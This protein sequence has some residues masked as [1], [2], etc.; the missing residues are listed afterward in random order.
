MTP[1]QSSQIS[2]KFQ[3]SIPAS[4]RR[5]LKLE[6]GDRLNWRII[7]RNDKALVLA[8][9]TAKNLAKET[10]GLGKHLWENIDIKSYINTLRNEWELSK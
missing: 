3:T 10:R 9:P 6:P 5:V 7:Y 2:P 8:E 1:I 4:I